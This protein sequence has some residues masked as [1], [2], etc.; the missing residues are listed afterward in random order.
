MPLD[1]EWERS[2]GGGECWRCGGHGWFEM[3]MQESD[4]RRYGVELPEGAKF[5][6]GHATVRCH[7]CQPDEATK[8][9]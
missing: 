5:V 3:P 1:Q 6:R 7:V 8:E 9:D 2:G 4:F